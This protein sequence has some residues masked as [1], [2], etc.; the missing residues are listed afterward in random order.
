MTE[1]NAAAELHSDHSRCLATAI[2]FDG[3]LQAH[4]ITA[5]EEVC[6]E[7]KPGTPEFAVMCR[8]LDH[9][10]LGYRFLKRFFD[11][12][13]SLCA[14]IVGF[15]PGLLLSVAI[16][17]DTKGS[18]I[19]SQV[20]VGKWGKPFRI[21]KFRT[22]VAD[23][24]NVEKYF[25]PEQLEVWKRERKVDGDPRITKLGSVL[26]ATSFDETVQ[27]VN[28]LLGQIS[29]IG[30]RVITFSELEHFGKDKD[31]LLSVPPGI[32]GL[33]QIGDR[34][35]ATFENGTRQA[36]ELDYAQRASLRTDIAVFFGTFSAMFVRR[37]GR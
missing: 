26:R 18:P 22:M 30:P 1:V 20:R 37:T 11:V 32:T 24:D 19:Y 29:I 33:W 35:A 4:E 36:I 23:S 13:F 15:I 16:A 5:S 9:R 27:F 3:S 34:N 12:A 14:I 10:S 6:K 21:Y 31:L 7:L 28:V 17:I 2:G 8:E 25:T